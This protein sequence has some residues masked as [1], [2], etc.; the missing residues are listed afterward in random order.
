[1]EVGVRVIPREKE[2]E[3]RARTRAPYIIEI[4][5]ILTTFVA[6]ATFQLMYSTYDMTASR[7]RES[8]TPVLECMRGLLCQHHLHR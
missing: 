5:I 4:H 2:V 1:M 7:R 6:F 3:S 8:E